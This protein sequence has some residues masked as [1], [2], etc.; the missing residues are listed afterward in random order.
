MA[1]RALDGKAGSGRKRRLPAFLDHF[2]ARE[3]KI[4]FR[5]WVAVWVASL[6]IFIDPVATDFGQATFF[7]W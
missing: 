4:F 3:L 5:C 6:L 2:S 7:A 1:D